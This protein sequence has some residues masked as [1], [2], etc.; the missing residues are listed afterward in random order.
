MNTTAI[1]TKQNAKGNRR[2]LR[3]WTLTIRTTIIAWQPTKPF[4]VCCI[5]FTVLELRKGAKVLLGIFQRHFEH[6]TLQRG[7]VLVAERTSSQVG[8]GIHGHDRQVQSKGDRGITFNNNSTLA[9]ELCGVDS[10]RE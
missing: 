2:P 3:I 6:Q 4:E 1:R 5:H 7:Q 10:G 9:M 8:R